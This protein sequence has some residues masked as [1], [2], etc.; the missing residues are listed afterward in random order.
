MV[1]YEPIESLHKH[2][3]TIGQ[4]MSWPNELELEL[5]SMAQGGDAIGRHEGRAVFAA[6][7][8]PRE[9]VRV[10]L[11]DRQ[12]AFARGRVIEVLQPAPERVTSFCPLEQRCG[13]ADW[14]WIDYDAQRQF[15]AAILREQLQHLGGIDVAVTPSPST[16]AE[17]T[18]GY[19]TTVD[20]HV[21]GTQIGYYLPGSRRV[22][23]VPSCCLHHP[24]INSALDTFRP[25]LSSNVALR[26]ISLRCSPS[27]GEVLAIVDGKGPLRELAQA[28][29]QTFPALV[30]VTHS[31]TRQALVGR[32]WLE[33]RIGP[34]RFHVSASSFFQINAHQINQI[35]E[36]VQYLLHLTPSKRLLDLYCGVGLF[37]LTNAAQAKQLSELRSGH[38]LSRMPGAAHS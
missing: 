21:A 29:Q 37:A 36:R 14:R 17:A 31:T 32:S 20:L 27:S 35:V 23:D 10:R 6:G 24:L 15:K 9:L 7:G 11:F 33:Q 5:T 16:I 18:R 38:Q 34:I 22:T 28:W 1:R 25:L 2:E 12:K 26:S 4:L 3:S 30:G 8:L 13:A 19:R